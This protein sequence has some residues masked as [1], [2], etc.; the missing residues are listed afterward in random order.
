[1]AITADQVDVDREDQVE[2]PGGSSRPWLMW[3]IAL[4]AAAVL[5][6]GGVSVNFIAAG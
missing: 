1:M 4:L 2:S 6:L 5:V 3:A